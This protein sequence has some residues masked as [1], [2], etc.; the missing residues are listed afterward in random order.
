MKKLLKLL[1]G[2]VAVVGVLVGV[3]YVTTYKT[4]LEK[5][6]ENV[7]V[8]LT[9]GELVSLK[10]DGFVDVETHVVISFPISEMSKV[11]DNSWSDYPMETSLSEEVSHF[12]D[13][14]IID[15]SSIH[16]GYYKIIE[17][18][19]YILK[20]LIYDSINETMYYYGI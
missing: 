14:T 18:N 9:E 16:S 10:Q 17:D 20:V 7:G 8:D 13:K 1:L 19:E 2:V 12:V 3:T 6:S 4:P 5:L 15:M 11:M